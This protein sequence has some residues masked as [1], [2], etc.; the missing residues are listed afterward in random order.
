MDCAACAYYTGEC[1]CKLHGKLETLDGWISCDE[2]L[3]ANQKYMG[4]VC[5]GIYNFP[6]LSRTGSE[7]TAKEK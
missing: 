7:A 1:L 3:D 6:T 4:G 2:F 5:C